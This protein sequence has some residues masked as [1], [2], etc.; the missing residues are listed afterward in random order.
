MQNRLQQFRSEIEK[1]LID[2]ILPFWSNKMPDEDNGGFYGQITGKDEIIPKAHKG[3]VL[4]ARILWT[5]SAAYRIYKNPDY[6]VIATRARNYII[7]HFIDKKFGGVYWLLDYKGNPVET[8][9]QIYAQGFAIYGLSEY[10]RVTS[11]TEA[12][13]HAIELYR[14]IEKHSFDTEKNGYLEAFT[15]DWQ[16]IADMRLS[17]KD[18]NEQKT[19]N[20]HLHILEPYSNLYRVW[21]NDSLKSQLKT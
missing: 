19:M 2:N 3:S 6:L 13:N 18:A 10:Y 1:E 4:N 12:L 17:E 8:K 20:T 7:D 11:D 5:F 14:L 21:E 15:E 16:P 9:K